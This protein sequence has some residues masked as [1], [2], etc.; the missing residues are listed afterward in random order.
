M[1]ILVATSEAVPFSKTGGL[2]DVC[3][4]LPAALARLGH[5]TAVILPAYRQARYC[6]VPI[7]PLGI[8][9]IVPVATKTV[10]GHLLASRLP[11]SQ[12]PVYLVQQDHYFDRDE[13]YAV[14]GEDYV[15]NCERFVF[16][17]R[18]VMEAV[19]L[20][21][22]QLDV[23]HANDWQ[24]GLVP[25]YLKIQYHSLPRYQQLV[26][27]FTI[28]NMG[29]QGQFWHWDMLLTGLDWKHFN[30][31][32]M[33]YHGKLNLLKTGLVF[34][35]SISTVSPR[36]AQEIQTREFGCGLEGVLRHRR[37]VLS[38]I[39]NGVNDGEWNPASDPFLAA[40]Y[41]VETVGQGKPVCKAALQDEVGLPQRPEVPLV[42]MIGRLAD[43]KGVDLVAK[44]IPQW[45]EKSHMQWV[46]LGKG[47]PKYHRLF[48]DFARRHSDKVAVRLEFSDE[49]AHR[50]E[51]G[52]DM[53][54]MPSRY[55]P[56]G[57]NQMYSLKY[58]TLPVVRQ[59]GGLADTI[60]DTNQQTLADR[61]AN[62]FSFRE[63]NPQALSETLRRA[64]E[65]YHRREVWGQLMV[66]GMC[67]DWSWA[68]SAA[69]YVELYRQT[70]NR[71]RQP[72]ASGALGG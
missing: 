4:A 62:G 18:A 39:L 23:I 34:A 30:W 72:S 20:L 32:Q 56:C 11:G 16:F 49:L 42:G 14:D 60:V 2:A 1:K 64:Y 5:Q 29:Y 27:V 43:Q 21:E 3:G 45:V 70:V 46:V 35:D 17:S 12:V 54:L 24:T 47:E 31:R 19:R 51:A 28:H 59:T 6:G 44:V 7:E 41:T 71:V 37:D 48:E 10:T 25:A 67:Q 8:D 58:G 61:T 26:C 52:A 68:R 13:L 38:G 40:N 53:F 33:E 57:L 36:Y 22:L 50:I 15:D 9:F 69:E 63:D 65:A 55:E 66:T